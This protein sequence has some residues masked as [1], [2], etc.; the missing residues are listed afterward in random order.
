MSACSKGTVGTVL[1][2][3][4]VQ[5]FASGPRGML[6]GS[7]V[8]EIALI[9]WVEHQNSQSYHWLLNSTVATTQYSIHYVRYN[10]TQKT[11]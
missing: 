11:E 2:V 1:E 8:S 10:E 7:K 5:S 4:I 9:T 6:N 3:A